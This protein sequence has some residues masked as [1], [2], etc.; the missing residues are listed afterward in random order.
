MKKIMKE[1]RK[2]GLA[3]NL[4]FKNLIKK[5]KNGLNILSQQN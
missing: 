3:E 5:K 2:K 1:V 4:D